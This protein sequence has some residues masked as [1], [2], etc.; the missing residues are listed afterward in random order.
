MSRWVAGTA[1]LAVLLAAPGARAQERRGPFDRVPKAHPAYTAVRVLES[2]GFYTGTPAGTFNGSREL[3]RYEFASA[4]ERIYRSLQPRVLAATAPGALREDL[5]HFRALL[6]EFGSDVSALGPDA[7]E[8]RRQVDVLAERLS[9]LEKQ[10]PPAAPRAEAAPAPSSGGRVR[11]GIQRALLGAP[12]DPIGLAQR[13]AFL[14]PATGP[15]LQPDLGSIGPF[16]VGVQLDGPNRGLAADRAPF[17]DPAASLG[18]RAQLSLPFGAY[19]LSAF[20]N[21]RGALADSYAVWDPYIHYGPGTGVGGAIGGPVSR[22]LAFQLEGASLQ[23]DLSRTLYLKGRV[24]YAISSRLSL[25]L[26]LERFWDTGLAGGA[27]DRSA[28]MMGI[29][30]TLGPNSRMD[31]LFRRDTGDAGRDAGGSSAITQFSVRF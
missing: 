2:E 30:R 25:D 29:G 1:L 21:Q 18:Y 7:A 12:R 15:G 27:A 19:T 17:E 22:H 10:A 5:A 31:L 9:R 14:Q 20:Y 13:P 23:D 8:I 11:Y 4:I 28:F 6:D 24:H 3:T 16:G 26:G